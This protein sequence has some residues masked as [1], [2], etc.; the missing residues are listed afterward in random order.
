MDVKLKERLAGRARAGGTE[1]AQVE[2]ATG[3]GSEG[4]ELIFLVALGP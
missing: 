3:C 2:E 4:L 1:W